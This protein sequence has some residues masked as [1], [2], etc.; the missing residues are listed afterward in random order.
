MEDKFRV[1]VADDEKL[2]ANNI[3]MN[4]EKTHPGFRVAGIAHDGAEALRMTEE[5]LP[6]V[7]FSDIKMPVIN[8]LELFGLLAERRPGIKKVIISGYDDFQFVRDALQNQAFDYLLKPVNREELRNTLEKMYSELNSRRGEIVAESSQSPGQIVDAV[9]H[10]IRDNLAQPINFS[11]TAARY[12]FSG[13]YLTRIFRNRVGISPHRFLTECRIFTAK[14]LLTDTE[15]LIRE[16]GA[17]VGYTDSFHFCK[18]FKQNTGISPSQY[19]KKSACS[20]DLIP[21]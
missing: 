2:I 19:R 14:Q 6:H 9:Q 11:A 20:G 15:L 10:Y 1:I 5:L 8:G 17:R 3:A 18:I 4:I 12:G 13:S 16:V 7:V 21:E